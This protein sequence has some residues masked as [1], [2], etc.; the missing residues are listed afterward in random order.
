MLKALFLREEKYRLLG[1]TTDKLDLFWKHVVTSVAMFYQ[2][3]YSFLAPRSPWVIDV[4]STKTL[5][6]TKHKTK[7]SKNICQCHEERQ[8][9]IIICLGNSI[10]VALSS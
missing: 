10:A 5:L 6:K 7:T 9:A 4:F 3:I 8:E 2:C 1:E